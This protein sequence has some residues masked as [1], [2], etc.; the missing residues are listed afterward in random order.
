MLDFSQEKTLMDAGYN[1]V[2]GVDEVGRGPWAGPVVAAAVVVNP[3]FLPKGVRDSKKLSAKQ[4]EHIATELQN[5]AEVGIGVATVAEIDTHNILQATYLAMQR[6]LA[7]LPQP[8][9]YALIDGNRLPA[10]LPM[11]AQAVVK[12]DDKV[13]SIACASVAAKVYRD[14]LMAKL[15][16]EYPHFGW[17]SNAGYGTKAHQLGL[18][19]QGVTPH[20]RTSFAPIKTLLEAK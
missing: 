4:R 5:Q 11:P 10:G 7:A 13:L 1:R 2:A 6:A 3:L 15:H 12:G 20:H 18:A 16:Q 8:V 19:S 14:R 17:D 9:D